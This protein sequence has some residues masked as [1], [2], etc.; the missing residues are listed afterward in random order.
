[1]LADLDGNKLQ[2]ESPGEK[3]RLGASHG[4]DRRLGL[5]APALR[6]AEAESQDWRGLTLGVQE[7][8]KGLR[9]DITNL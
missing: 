7:V 4:N 6:G 2:T 9:N 1:M 5:T 8:C 3:S